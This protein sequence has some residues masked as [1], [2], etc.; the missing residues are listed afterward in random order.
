[1]THH[2]TSVYWARLWHGHTQQH[3]VE[4]A[5]RTGLC[6]CIRS[7][8]SMPPPGALTAPPSIAALA[9]SLGLASREPGFVQQVR[10]L[11][12]RSLT[13]RAVVTAHMGRC[14]D[15]MF[16]L[17]TLPKRWRCDVSQ[18]AHASPPALH[19][20]RAA[21]AAPAL[22]VSK[23]SMLDCRRIDTGWSHSSRRPTQTQTVSS[24]PAVECQSSALR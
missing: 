21:G 23:H 8:P 22:K 14:P 20:A 17:D 2:V 11:Q 19:S 6:L 24:A 12:A 5:L 13:T 16:Y 7:A 3:R 18:A 9:T 10:S 4:E 15:R 1:M